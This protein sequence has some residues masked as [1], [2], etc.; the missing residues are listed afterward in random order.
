M[1]G[2][3]GS[4]GSR[5]PPPLPVALKLSLG[6][7]AR[8][9]PQRQHGAS[10]FV[11]GFSTVQPRTCVSQ[12][13]VLCQCGCLSFHLRTQTVALVLTPPIEW[14]WLCQHSPPSEDES[15]LPKAAL[16]LA[17]EALGPRRFPGSRCLG[18]KECIQVPPAIRNG[19]PCPQSSPS[20]MT[21]GGW[22]LPLLGRYSELWGPMWPLPL[23]PPPVLWSWGPGW[24]KVTT[25]AGP[26]PSGLRLPHSQGSWTESHF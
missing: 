14:G 5:L 25:L 6:A 21:A 1:G 2:A 20:A 3:G 9:T 10:D 16:R 23:G 18:R 19:V 7:F 13:Y 26:L 15:V 4:R 24:S 8:T 22:G 17:Q 11:P 12:C